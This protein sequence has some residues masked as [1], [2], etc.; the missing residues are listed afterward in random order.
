M[1]RVAS[2]KGETIMAGTSAHPLK[3][4]LGLLTFDGTMPDGMPRWSDLKAMAQRAE[5]LGYDTATGFLTTLCLRMP[6]RAD[7][8]SP[9]GNAGPF[10]QRSPRPRTASNSAPL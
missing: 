5:A 9:S 1:D 6:A 10:S 2:C 3:V 4:G 8:G 7:H